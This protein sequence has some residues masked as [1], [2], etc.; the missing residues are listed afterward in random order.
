MSLSLALRERGLKSNPGSQL[1]W[2]SLVSTAPVRRN[3][4]RART[5]NMH[6]ELSALL[7]ISELSNQLDKLV[8]VHLGDPFIADRLRIDGLEYPRRWKRNGV[9]MFQTKFSV[10]ITGLNIRRS[11]PSNNFIGVSPG[12]CPTLIYFETS[13]AGIN[14]GHIMYLSFLSLFSNNNASNR[15]LIIY[16]M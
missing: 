9:S 11:G 15:I 14:Y 3:L 16:L 5:T 8:H 13:R 1:L 12:V 2:E 6:F 10:R 7:H 4:W